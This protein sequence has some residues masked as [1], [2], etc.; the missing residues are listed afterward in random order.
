[1]AKLGE[2]WRRILFSF[3]RG[4]MDRELAEEMRQHLE[5]K[6]R[7]NV[8]NG[9]SE[10]EA[11]NAAQRQLG[12][13]TR[14]EE[15][16]REQWGFPFLESLVQDIRYG[17]RGL[18]KAPGFTV[19]ATITLALGI[20]ATTTI[21][22]VVNT[23]L[24]RPL[25][26]KDSGRLAAIHTIS[27]KFPEFQLSESKPD[28]DDMQSGIHAFEAMAIS[29]DKRA[30][31]TAPGEPEE[32]QAVAVSAGYLPLLG[33]SP[34]LG[35][36]FQPED[37]ERKNGNVAL[38]SQRLW[39]ERF[40]SD[41]GVVGKTITLEE[42]LYTVIGVMPRH[43]EGPGQ[44]DVWLPFLK[45][46]E[47]ASKRSNWF[48]GV[49]AKIK[50]EQGMQA[51]QTE[52]D[53]LAARLS[54]QYPESDAG[55]KFKLTPLQESVVGDAKS[56]LMLLLG[57]VGFLLLIAC[58]NVSNLILSRGVQR[59]SEMAIRAALGASRPRILRQ[60]LIESLLLS[61][62]GGAAGILLAI[63]GVAAYRALA[64]ASVPRINELHADLTIAWIA[65]GLASVAGI[66]CGLA[67]ALHT[68][69]PDLNLALKE[70]LVSGTP[71]RF[72]LRGALVVAEVAL[73]LILLDG[74]AL[75]VQS[76][77]RMLTVDTGFRTDH[78]LTAELNLPESHYATP[79]AR[80]LFARQ[81]LDT[82]HANER[83]KNVAV[84]DSPALT[85]SLSMMMFDAGSLGAGDKTTTLQNRT[86]APG[87][88][89][90]MRIPLISGRAFQQTDVKSA[91]RVAIINEA[92]MK[93]YF[94]RQ[95]ALGKILKFGPDAGD[96]SQIVGVVADTR[97]VDV[98][99]APRPQ[100]YLP[101]FQ[102]A[103]QT[104]HLFIR[105]SSDP[106]SLANEFRTT[107]WSIDKDQPVSHVQTMSE[108]I[109]VSVSEPRFRAWLLGA[110]AAA[111]LTLTLV[112]IYGVVSY[113][114]G[115]RTREIGIR[116]ALGAQRGNVLQLVL[117][118]G[119]R[120]TVVGAIAGVLGSL[121]L[122]RLLKSELF[123]IKPTDPVTLIGAALLMLLVA[124]A[125]CYLP[126][127]RATRI[128][129]LVALR[130]E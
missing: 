82:L 80:L 4:G 129:P 71:T 110:F 6:A 28:F 117:G 72:S 43:F 96:H 7:E 56:G 18:R 87:F 76:M 46:S 58:A 37:E 29:E 120:L 108:V 64:P 124:V 3:R 67:P 66:L 10:E 2:F 70:R 128:D 102:D 74:S 111:G 126:A 23:V 73:A 9:M 25:P 83:L 107:V 114:A 12:N 89:E 97:D 62:L 26:Y 31:L 81:L 90:T 121:A 17:L 101:L 69:R 20:G 65:L 98:K 123:S 59:Q 1:M 19:V 93:R 105:T 92:M 42:K 118:Q 95:D 21:F 119:V 32:I 44:R 106:L 109:S 116:V 100:V 15:Q 50:A 77:V 35:R 125:A 36:T 115:Q 130:H 78:M 49:L 113:M 103:S 79:E 84:S 85:H 99:S 11:R 63:Y 51:A 61:S 40:G 33:V 16:S 104:L 34:V 75:M 13:L 45:S 30:N 54:T 5:L 88:F 53:G 41:P 112:G 48:F 27:P 47:A 94:P 68:S 122:T 14:M 91:P 86:V 55:I 60:L 57:A 8:A 39:R 127:R 24:V 38:L 22:S 52:L